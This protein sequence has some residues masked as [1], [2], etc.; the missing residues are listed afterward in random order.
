MAP[1]N[2]FESLGVMGSLFAEP[3][4]RRVTPPAVVPPP[5]SSFDDRGRRKTKA[6]DRSPGRSPGR[7]PAS[8]SRSRSPRRGGSP[9]RG[10]PTTATTDAGDHDE[11]P[12]S[13]SAGQRRAARHTVRSRIAQK[14]PGGTG[15]AKALAADL[16]S[17]AEHRVA[18]D[19]NY[20]G[21]RNLPQES[22]P[23]SREAAARP[24]T[25]DRWRFPG[26]LPEVGDDPHSRGSGR[27]AANDEGS[28]AS[29]GPGAA[30]PSPTRVPKRYHKNAQVAM[31]PKGLAPGS[32]GPDTAYQDETG[33]WYLRKFPTA[34]AAGREEVG[35]LSV[36]W[37]HVSRGLRPVAR[38]LAV[39]LKTI[40]GA[41][42]MPSR[43]GLGHFRKPDAHDSDDAAAVAAKAA[44]EA[45]LTDEEV[46]LMIAGV[47]TWA[48]MDAA[49]ARVGELADVEKLVYGE[50][51]GCGP[52]QCRPLPCR[53]SRAA[54][55]VLF[56]CVAAARRPT[57]RRRPHHVLPYSQPPPALDTCPGSPPS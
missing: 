23:V 24:G 50:L 26:G 56:R 10:T 48:A 7:S 28:Y 55:V 42:E 5:P 38:A 29:A 36:A 37:D 33:Q 43:H 45:Q 31:R 41:G 3:S 54:A 52:R 22:P 1:A 17:Y 13:S 44:A 2:D 21:P 9:G 30:P 11:R 40:E 20:L 49:L 19:A 4:G 25:G 27:A 46:S 51:R 57:G 47:P 12:G 15:G 18:L 39:E 53:R 32:E 6:R 16:V 34:K 14:S 35:H 8:P